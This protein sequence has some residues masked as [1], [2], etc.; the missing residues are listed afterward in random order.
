MTNGALVVVWGQAVR[1]R[2]QLALEV[3]GEVLAYYGRLRQAGEI[4]SFEPIALEPSG[5]VLAGL[6][7]ARGD[8]ARLQRIRLSDEFLRLSNRSLHVV[9]NFGV[10]TAHLGDDL[11]R[12]YA[13]WGA[14]AQALTASL[15]GAPI[16]TGTPTYLP[17]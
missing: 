6:L 14:Q 8:P 13:N 3:F 1:G 7:I 5:G 2:E 4:E 10:H 17:A 9:D 12:V 15:A 11:Q 16:A